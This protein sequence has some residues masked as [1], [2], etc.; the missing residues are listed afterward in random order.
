MPNLSKEQT[1]QLIL[2][3]LLSLIIIIV[4]VMLVG[5][6]QGRKIVQQETDLENSKSALQASNEAISNKALIQTGLE[7]AQKKIASIESEMPS[8][9]SA[10]VWVIESCIAVAQNHNIQDF[11][12]DP[13][14]ITPTPGEIQL[15]ATFPV[16]YKQATVRIH[17]EGYYHDLGKFFAD[18]ENRFKYVHLQNFVIR[19]AAD[20]FSSSS[21]KL[22][23]TV[24]LVTI[25]KTSM[26]GEG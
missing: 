21:E 24:N 6:Y 1:Q 7:T 2:T 23:F 19:P 10:L 14:T 20:P 8:E 9:G 17:G 18:L 4:L 13:P 3:G 15:L 12:A 22:R 5:D 25:I 11:D 16:E 26:I